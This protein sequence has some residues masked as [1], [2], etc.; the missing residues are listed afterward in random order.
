MA[1]TKNCMVFNCQG[2]TWISPMKYISYLWNIP[3]FRMKHGWMFAT[4]TVRQRQLQVLG[5]CRADGRGI[6]E[7]LLENLQGD[8]RWWRYWGVIILL[9]TWIKKQIC[10]CI[11][12]YI[13]IHTYI[14]IY[15]HTYVYIY[16]NIYIYIYNYIYTCKYRHIYIYIYIDM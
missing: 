7:G 15:I 9:K 8:G 1:I 11:H 14:Y 10:I 2:K 12:L 3:F 4:G 6:G 16:I 13:Y 5:A